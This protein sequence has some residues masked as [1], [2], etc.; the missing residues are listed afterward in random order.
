MMRLPNLGIDAPRGV[1]IAVQCV[2][3]RPALLIPI[4][5]GSA[6][7]QSPR[8]GGVAGDHKGFEFIQVEVAVV[9]ASRTILRQAAVGHNVQSQCGEL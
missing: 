3:N 9:L 7:L 8:F 1:F 4:R 6:N 2:G 5:F